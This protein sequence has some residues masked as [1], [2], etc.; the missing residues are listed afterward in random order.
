SSLL[1][2]DGGLSGFLA[3]GGLS[4]LFGAGGLDG[5][6]GSGGLN[7]YLGSGGLS[8]L[9]RGT[10]S[11]NNLLSPADIA[12]LTGSSTGTLTSDQVTQAVGVELG[13]LVLATTL[14]EA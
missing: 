1:A 10:G 5:F 11:I 7:A 6:F 14:L 9:I 3:N 13:E 4:A 8:A 12:A 2:S